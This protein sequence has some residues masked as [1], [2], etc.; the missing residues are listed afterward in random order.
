MDSLGLT[1]G[2]RDST[3]GAGGGGSLPSPPRRTATQFGPGDWIGRYRIVRL[4]GRGGMG[5]VYEAMQESPSRPIALKVMDPTLASPGALR[6]F[7]TEAQ[8]LGR[9]DHEGIARIF[10]AGTHREPRIDAE[11]V[12]YYAME[13]IHDAR[14]ITDYAAAKGL[15]LRARLRLAAAVCDAVEHGHREGVLHRDLK[16][17]NVV[18]DAQGRVKVIDF[19]I[20]RVTE[21]ELAATRVTEVGQLVGTLQYMSP[22]Q[23]DGYSDRLD[24]RSDVYAL[25][26]LLYELVCGRL[27]YDVTGKT[28][29]QA[30]HV[31]RETQ[32]AAPGR[33]DVCL[34]GDI[35]TIVLKAMHKDR[36]RRYAHAADLAQDLRRHLDGLPIRARQDSV[37]Y[38]VR[39]QTA[40]WTVRKPEIAVILA[41]ALVASIIAGLFESERFFRS[42]PLH[43]RLLNLALSGPPP[44][45]MAGPWTHAAVVLFDTNTDFPALA[46]SAG[47]EGVT[48]A[49]TVAG[50][51]ADPSWR[52][53][54]GAL[55]KK[56]AAAG[57]AA[58][59]WDQTFRPVGPLDDGFVEGV[60]ALNSASPRIDV[61]ATRRTWDPGETFLN[62]RFRDKVLSGAALLDPM[63]PEDNAREIVWRAEL[64][65]RKPDSSILPS[66]S[67]LAFALSLHP[68]TIPAVDYV[69]D[70]HI[71]V[72][73]NGRDARAP[74]VEPVPAAPAR[75]VEVSLVEPVL[76]DL[77]QSSAD[78]DEAASYVLHMPGPDVLR[79]ATTPYEEVFRM[80]DAELRARFAGKVVVI[81]QERDGDRPLYS[82]GRRIPGTYTLAALVEM[83]HR[84]ASI[85]VVSGGNRLV[86]AVGF[87]FAGALAA[88]PAVGS[89]RRLALITLGLIALSAVL[90][91][92][93]YLLLG[94]FFNPVV[95][96]SGLVC[97]AVVVWIVLE[98]RRRH[99]PE[100]SRA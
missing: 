79:A 66:A 19:G 51:S 37:V 86:A 82:D 73:F 67:L 55:M 15:D 76:E 98:F 23:F 54:H 13:F 74:G 93:A 16:P 52:G 63:A 77:T 85:H 65:L 5:V 48:P 69:G 33:L 28:V 58:V 53:V 64:A 83:L 49:S 18:V 40:I 32:P 20:A 88:I 92:G 29:I 96:T 10:E 36:E 87:A 84:G 94:L 22:E 9:L 3:A 57:P 43:L 14:P 24:D 70:R 42:P 99:A 7:E 34:K 56:L 17:E 26:V 2:D 95:P 100:G 46:A 31:V 50:M 30:A 45:P 89:P 60:Q 35:E 41:T 72:R 27:P 1:M 81:G 21:P 91:W 25:G 39:K 47:V 4:L 62:E 78:A 11:P 6:R 71:K 80:T 59:L 8:L 68:G 61:I 44:I 97:A 38:R 75:L 12:P 90:S